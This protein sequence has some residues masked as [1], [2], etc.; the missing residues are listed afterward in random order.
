MTKLGWYEVIG[1]VHGIPGDA[2]SGMALL[3]QA[4]ARPFAPAQYRLG[5]LLVKGEY[6]VTPDPARG[7]D[8][9][10]RSASLA[11]KIEGTDS[12]RPASALGSLFRLGARNVPRD[13]AE[14][15]LW[16]ARSVVHCRDPYSH[17][18]REAIFNVSE[19]AR[20]P[21]TTMAWLLL[22]GKENVRDAP[23]LSPEQRQAAEREA[24]RLLQRVRDSEKQYSAPPKE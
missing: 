6:G 7:L 21:V 16:L 17:A 12:T 18:M 19:A 10:K 11:C 2:K 9:I 14:A 4:A 15:E 23:V 20:G 1:T 13:S 24:R 3:E 5:D 22:S 8:L